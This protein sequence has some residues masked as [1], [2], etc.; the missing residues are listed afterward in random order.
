MNATRPRDS[1]A[2]FAVGM[3]GCWMLSG[4]WLLEARTA[5]EALPVPWLMIGLPL[6]VILRRLTRALSRPLRL[7]LGLIGGVI[8]ALLLIT[9]CTFPADVMP[10]S[11]GVAVSLRR[12]F[13]VQGGLNPVQLSALAAAAT[14][15]G[16]LRLAAVRVG[17]DQILGEFQFGVPILL[18]VFVCA[19]Q[20][21]AALPAPAPVVL[22][23]FTFFLLGVATARGGDRGG[24]LQ[25]QA[26]S[27][28][29]AAIVFNAC[30]AL[31]VGLL[32]T[33]VVTPGALKLV[34]GFLE[35]L[36][37]IMVEWVVRFITFLAQLIPQPEIKAHPMGGIAGPAP[38]DRSSIPELLRIPDYVRQIAGFLVSA[39]WVVLFG[40]SLWRMASQIAGW[41][42]RQMND[43]DGAE[44][45]TLR[46]AF[47][48]D[49]RRLLRWAR[50]RLKGWIA[51]RGYAFG[52]RP[53]TDTVPAE[54]AAVRRLYRAVLAWSAAGG[55][56]R[57]RHQTPHEFLVK[58]CE[59]HPEARAQLVLITEHYT[60]VRYGGRRPDP[61][62]V[63]RLESVWQN[64]RKMRK[65]RGT[66]TRKHILR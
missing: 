1:G 9:L 46:G 3:E 8:W 2:L 64:V 59:R 40:F 48:Q 18:I 21:N 12:L 27:R 19:A 22:S 51:W 11:A 54:A 58:L 6:A 15:T 36:W 44:V 20:W 28:W 33:A 57:G 43:G 37:D 5:P 53:A 47:R 24:W 42:R 4:L 7:S 61:E 34:L 16:G 26:R 41:L 39:F 38:Q 62:V 45:E 10:E 17:F 65:R 13:Q 50:R 55:C 49:L 60:D 30:L 56:P 23:F 35:T 25:G 29:L 52:R 14:W 31:G 32:L 66:Q 63:K